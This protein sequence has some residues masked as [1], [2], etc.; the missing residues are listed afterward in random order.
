M[1][2]APSIDNQS[3]TSML[4]LSEPG[5][6]GLDNLATP[7]ESLIMENESLP[8]EEEDSFAA[9]NESLPSEE[10]DSFA[11]GNDSFPT[12]EDVEMGDEI[13]DENATAATEMMGPS[14]NASELLVEEDADDLS[15]AQAQQGLTPDIDQKLETAAAATVGVTNATGGVENEEIT[16]VQQVI[17]N[18]AFAGSQGGGDMNVILNQISQ[19]VANNPNSTV[20][21]AIKKLAQE[22]SNGNIDEI[23]IATQQVGTQIAQGKDI[24]QTLV[25]ITNNV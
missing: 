20:A 6:E 7:N 13:Q 12:D 1:K 17:N 8:S 18:I 9:G 22:Y 23:D 2:P 16:N 3:D 10:E 11:A 25:Q 21:V 5:V 15:Q 24:E 14:D 19:L 4:N